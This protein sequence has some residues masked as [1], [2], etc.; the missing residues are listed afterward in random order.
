MAQAAPQLCQAVPVWPVCSCP[1]IVFFAL[2]SCFIWQPGYGTYGIPFWSNNAAD[3]Y[4]THVLSGGS[5]Y[6]YYKMVYG[7]GTKGK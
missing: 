4:N 6:V 7:V 5:G 3:S 2:L 1:G